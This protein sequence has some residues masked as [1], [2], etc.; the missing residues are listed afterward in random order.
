MERQNFDTSILPNGLTTL[1]AR[2]NTI[3]SLS[4]LSN[5]CPELTALYIGWCR[6]PPNDLN[7]VLALT[8]LDILCLSGLNIYTVEEISKLQV[9]PLTELFL[10]G[11]GFSWPEEENKIIEM[12]P[13][14]ELFLKSTD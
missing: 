10:M 14:C 13:A 5:I 3:T 8:N 11:N 4:T 1:D 6:N 7:W 9:L 12:F 2:R